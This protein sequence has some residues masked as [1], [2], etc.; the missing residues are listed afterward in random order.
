M[1]ALDKHWSPMTPQTEN[2]E[3]RKEGQ[4]SRRD[5]GPE[6]PRLPKTWGV[7]VCVHVNVCLGT[8]FMLLCYLHA[9]A[10]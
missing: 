7:C 3:E 10:L 6:E 2:R 1:P 5:F 4:R 9:V 8:A